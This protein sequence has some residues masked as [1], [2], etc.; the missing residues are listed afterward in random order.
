[1]IFTPYLDKNTE[2]SV[3]TPGSN[4]SHNTVTTTDIKYISIYN[5]PNTGVVSL[6]IEKYKLEKGTKP[7]E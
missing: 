7:T 6:S 2:T 5:L 1:M 3:G 4:L